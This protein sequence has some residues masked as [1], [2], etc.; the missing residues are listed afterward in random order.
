MRNTQA[1][2]HQQRG[3]TLIELIIVIVIIGILAAVAIPKFE[4]LAT[5]AKK[6]VAL[7][8]G[9]ALASATS[10]N[11]ARRSGGL[12]GMASTDCAA[13]TT[14]LVDIPGGYSVTATSTPLPIN[15]TS[16]SCNVNNTAGGSVV[17]LNMVRAYGAP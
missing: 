17:L 14:A 2:N 11:Y 13:L 16:G 10:I 6:A 4:D 8:I 9:G 15:G 12:G 1:L 7:G 3:F 5:D